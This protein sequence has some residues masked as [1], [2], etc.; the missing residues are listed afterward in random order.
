MPMKM[1]K[2]MSCQVGVTH[3]DETSPDSMTTP[4]IDE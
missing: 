3:T 1:P 4:T 2:A